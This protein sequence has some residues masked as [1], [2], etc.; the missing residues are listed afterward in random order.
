[1][2]SGAGLEGGT[3]PP[4]PPKE[5][6]NIIFSL[7]DLEFYAYSPEQQ[8]L[9]EKNVCIQQF[10]VRESFL[11]LTWLYEPD[12]QYLLDLGVVGCDV[13]DILGAV[14]HARDVHGH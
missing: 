12:V 10:I 4:P 5:L 11:F 14:L 13:E 8:S 9:L 7:E 2:N 6:R 1:M 3:W